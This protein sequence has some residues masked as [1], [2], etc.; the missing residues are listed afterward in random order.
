M[1]TNH[2][3]WYCRARSVDILFRVNAEE[4]RAVGVSGLTVPPSIRS[5]GIRRDAHGLEWVELLGVPSSRYSY[6]RSYSDSRCCLC[7]GESGRLRRTRSYFR[8]ASKQSGTASVQCRN[9]PFTRLVPDTASLLRADRPPPQ[10]GS[11]SAPFR[12][13]PTAYYGGLSVKCPRWKLRTGV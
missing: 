10:D 8:G 9:R 1:V 11:E 13:I 12:P 7:H 5:V 4:S 3:C 2:Q 6:P